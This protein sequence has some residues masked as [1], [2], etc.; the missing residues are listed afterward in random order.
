MTSELIILPVEKIQ[1]ETNKQI[2]QRK[3]EYGLYVSL[4]K[5]HESLESSLKKENINTQ[6]LFFIDCVST[7]QTQD[8]IVIHPTETETLSTAIN[9]FLK[10]IPGKKYLIIDTLSTLL[11]YNNENK[12]ARLIKE[13]TEQNT[14]DTEIIALSP[15]TKGEELL[16]KI[17]NFFDEVKK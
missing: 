1:T 16:N 7:E 6:R 17:F 5:P 2:K 4:N 8:K 11:I 3:N 14:K 13:I 12:V 9:Y 10:N 15:K